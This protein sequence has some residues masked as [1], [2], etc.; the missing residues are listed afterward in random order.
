MRRG[1]GGY[2]FTFR[3]WSKSIPVSQRKLYLAIWKYMRRWILNPSVEKR[4]ENPN[5]RKSVIM[6][7]VVFF[8]NTTENNDMHS[9]LSHASRCCRWMFRFWEPSSFSLQ[10]S[11]AQPSFWFQKYWINHCSVNYLL[12]S[13]VLCLHTRT[14]PGRAI[15]HGRRRC[16]FYLFT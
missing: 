1:K 5:L 2:P 9:C 10:Q 15:A 11:R 14:T 3:K 16:I 12:S 6:K 8:Y 13:I 4:K 7:Y